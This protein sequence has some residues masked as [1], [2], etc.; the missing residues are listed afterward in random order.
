MGPLYQENKNNEID[1]SLSFD[2]ADLGKNLKNGGK[3]LFKGEKGASAKVTGGFCK[4][5]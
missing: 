2:P 3:N 4:K 1:V 5:W